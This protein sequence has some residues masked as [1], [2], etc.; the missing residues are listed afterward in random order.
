MKKEHD[1]KLSFNTHT[2]THSLKRIIG[3]YYNEYVELNDKFE[4]MSKDEYSKMMIAKGENAKTEKQKNK[5]AE[6]YAENMKKYYSSN[7]SRSILSYKDQVNILNGYIGFKYDEIE[8]QLNLPLLDFISYDLNN[9]NE[10]IIF[11]INYFDLVMDILDKD[12]LDMIKL[13]KLYEVKF[14][15]D[16]AKNYYDKVVKEAKKMQ[17]I[18]KMCIDLVYQMNNNE[19]TLK[20]TKDLTREQRFFVFNQVNNH[21][22]KNISNNFKM[23]NVLDYNYEYVDSKVPE[24]II[25][26]IKA[27]DPKG[28]DIFHSYQY[29]TDNLYTAFYIMLYNMIGI[30]NGHV[31]ICGN[32]GRYFL[33]PKATISYCDRIVDGEITCKDIGSKEQQ[34]RKEEKNPIIKKH[35][36]IQQTKCTY[37]TRYPNE[38]YYKKDYD[39]FNK[40]ANEFKRKIKKEKATMEEFDKWLDTQDKTKQD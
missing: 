8:E 35:R 6:E 23:I 4:N 9:I 19:Y 14:I 1:I 33:T 26:V 11:F 34:K 18:F 29:E 36:R 37:S 3:Y 12:V 31:K 30:S 40:K 25:S 21:P 17:T 20:L 2:V 16:I 27:M 22:F 7:I 39:D 24:V 5:I 13:N 38:P 32:C 28:E 15:S 10:Y